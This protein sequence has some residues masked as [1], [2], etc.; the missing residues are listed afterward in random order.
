MR[1]PAV[2]ERRHHRGAFVAQHRI[3][4]D[5]EGDPGA[6]A[7]RGNGFTARWNRAHQDLGRLGRQRRGYRRHRQGSAAGKDGPAC[8]TMDAHGQ[9]LP[10]H[11][12]H[13]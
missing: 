13:Q 4:A 11:C 6:E 12:K 1:P 5:I 2:E 7:D 8:R 10:I 9:V 3:V